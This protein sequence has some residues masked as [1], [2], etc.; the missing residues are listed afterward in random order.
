MAINRKKWPV[1]IL[2]DT[3]LDLIWIKM[4]NLEAEYM[5]LD[6]LCLRQE[7]EPRDDLHVEEW[8]LDMPMLRCMYN[9]IQA[10]PKVV[11]YLSRLG[12]PLSLKAGNLQYDQY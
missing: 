3:S 2:K 4:L 11:I 1:L 8:K 5:W 10:R 7:D 12:H 9:K 6:I